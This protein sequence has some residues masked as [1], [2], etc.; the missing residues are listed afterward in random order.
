M[1]IRPEQRTRLVSLALVA[2]LAVG[3]C[4]AATQAPSA[5]KATGPGGPAV[6]PI[7]VGT[8][9]IIKDILSPTLS[10][11][12]NVQARSS[13]NLVPKISARLEKLNAD[14]GDEVKAGDVIAELDRAQLD[15]QVTQS[16]AAVIA[17][18]AKLEQTQVSAKQ[19]DVDAA[20][21][22]VDGALARLEQAEAGGRPEE[23]AAARA[24]LSQS[25]SRY[26]Q[27]AAGARPQDQLSL[28]AAIDQADAQRQ[29][30][31]AQLT[32][33]QQGLA[34]ATYRFEQAR[35]GQGGPN[36]RP[37]DIAQAEATVR[38]N[39]SK[40]EQIR[41]PRIE[42][43]RIAEAEV[44]AAE[45]DLEKAEED[46]DNC[47]KVTTRTTNESRS[48]TSGGQATTSNGSGGSTVRSSGQTST[49]RSTSTSR[50]SCNEGQKDALDAAIDSAKATLYGK[51]AALQKVRTPSPYDVQQAEQAVQLAGAN[52]QKLRY[53]GTSDVAALQLNVA[54][55]QAEVDRLQASVDQATATINSAQAKLDL[56]V[57]PDPNEVAQVQ[58]AMEKARA[59]LARTAN[60]DPFVVAN[61]QATY[62]NAVAQ[63]NSKLRPF[64]EQDI[65][66]AAAGV[67]QAAAALELSRVQA[68]EAVIRAPFDAV[69]SQKLMNPGAMASPNT[70][71]LGLVSREVEVVV[72]VE[73]AR[74]G[75]VQRGQEA[76]L[77]VSAFPGKVFP[78][79]VQAIAPS[80]DTRSRTFAVRVVPQ[81]QDG[82]LKDGMFA[83]VNIV[84]V[85]APALLVPNDAL[86]TRAGR[87]QV[88]VVD[89]DRV[90][91]RELK[92]G[93]TDGKR[94]AI[95]EGRVDAG[96]EVVMTDPEALT[97]GAA[98]VVE[99]RNVEPGSRPRTTTPTT[100]P[101][102][103]RGTLPEGQS[104][105]G[106]GQPAPGSG[107]S[108]PAGGQSAPGA[109]QTT[110][111]AGQSAP[112]GGQTA[113]GA[114][115]S[116][117]ASS[118]GGR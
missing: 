20:Q 61:A 50:Q 81:N 84:G 46:R 38:T 53:G 56:A 85:G 66:V 22:T 41:N 60:A 68:N 51:R 97:D 39:Q 72:Q 17:A 40:L 45:A 64:T 71:I 116:G 31:E 76:S 110:P 14:I 102:S 105:P 32:A 65:K 98:V 27:V 58:A 100:P 52:L 19:E 87:S 4:T 25:Q 74:L 80:A 16:E 91:A 70:P 21:A 10:Y 6:A 104:A 29:Q 44:M 54:Q 106:S 114:G 69:V 35:A 33:A 48:R 55:S 23:V 78:G 75:Q 15:S 88:F 82:S 92:L 26:Q 5:P 30:I 63:L 42:D 89:N 67:E 2:S 79:L 18:E 47:G 90:F 115:T 12:G 7:S 1:T 111:G 73:E 117:G 118:G 99:Q 101:T 9:P 107:Q 36:T 3:A 13:V 28:Q 95:L 103:P 86:V 83:Q 49:N 93:E 43:I 94:T 8:A 62:D 59:D 11:S 96:D 34:E 57:N 109:G 113:P 77:S 108:A 112:A 24:T 37:E